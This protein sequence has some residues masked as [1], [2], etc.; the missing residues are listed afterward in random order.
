V[1]ACYVVGLTKGVI[2]P[3][4]GL[5]RRFGLHGEERRTLSMGRPVAGSGAS[6]GGC[7]NGPH[8]IKS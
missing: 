1:K 3:R 4:K 5:E 6:G 2:L 7:L 8:G